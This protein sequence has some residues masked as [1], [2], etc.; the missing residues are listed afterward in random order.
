MDAVVPPPLPLVQPTTSINPCTAH[1]RQHKKNEYGNVCTIYISRVK[2]T[3]LCTHTNTHNHTHASTDGSRSHQFTCERRA[4][5]FRKKVERFQRVRTT[6]TTS[7]LARSDFD[8]GVRASRCVR[9]GQSGAI[10]FFG[11]DVRATL[12]G[13]VGFAEA[14]Y[15]V[16][17][18]RNSGICES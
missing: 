13:W 17:S 18:L 9:C 15:R 14:Q 11:A 1:T 2:C 4:A 6:S 7:T 16:V 8:V 12:S 5:H 10:R 3:T